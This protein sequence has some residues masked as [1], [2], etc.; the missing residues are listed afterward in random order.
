LLSIFSA[1]SV[2]IN[3]VKGFFLLNSHRNTST[4]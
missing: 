3:A 4:G 1:L 2:K